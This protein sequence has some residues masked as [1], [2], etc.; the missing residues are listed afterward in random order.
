[1][2][3]TSQELRNAFPHAVRLI[4]RLEQN[5]YD[6]RQITSR[7]DEISRTISRLESEAEP[8][9]FKVLEQ[10][11]KQRLKLKDEITIQLMKLE[12]QI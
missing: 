5:N 6:F 2:I 12:R 9:L 4:E 10:L 3:S 1:M 8:A 7:Y 11:K